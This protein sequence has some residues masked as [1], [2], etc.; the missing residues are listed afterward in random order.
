MFLTLSRFFLLIR[1][2]NY[3]NLLYF[4]I[5]K[6]G[7]RILGAR[8]RWG[9]LSYFKCFLNILQIVIHFVS[10]SELCKSGHVSSTL[11]VRYLIPVFLNI[12]LFERKLVNASD[13]FWKI[14]WLMSKIWAS[15]SMMYLNWIGLTIMI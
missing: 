12:K 3:S 15:T 11:V 10:C 8:I 1:I 14:L 2:I 7:F 5:Y 13:S 4:V 6:L 9:G